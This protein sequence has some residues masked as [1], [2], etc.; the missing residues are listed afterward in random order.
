MINFTPFQKDIK[1]D[2]QGNLFQI[3]MQQYFNKGGK[4]TIQQY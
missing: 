3:L 2:V 4:A 1:A